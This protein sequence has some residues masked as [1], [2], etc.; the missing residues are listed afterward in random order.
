[1]QA[2]IGEYEFMGMRG[3][4]I[5]AGYLF[6]SV[7]A[8][9]SIA[10]VVDET[11]A[12]FDKWA[13]AYDANDSAAVAS[14]YAPD[15]V[16][17]GTTSTQLV[18]GRPAVKAYFDRIANTGY[19]VVLIE[20]KIVPL[21]ETKALAVGFYDF[22]VVRDGRSTL[23]PSRFTMVLVKRDGVWSILHHHSSLRMTGTK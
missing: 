10:G 20:R 23:S 9:P 7:F 22:T 21:D 8:S 2:A 1:M 5:L 17:L 6:A 4:F 18:I 19:K 13:T 12:L 15:A 16:H 11:N 3:V 14:L